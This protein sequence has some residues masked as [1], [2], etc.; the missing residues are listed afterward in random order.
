MIAKKHMHDNL[1]ELRNFVIFA[2]L[3]WHRKHQVYETTQTIGSRQ[4]WFA[5][6]ASSAPEPEAE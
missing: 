4:R 6:S 3:S 1:R 5:F 2:I